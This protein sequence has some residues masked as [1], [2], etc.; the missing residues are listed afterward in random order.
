MRSFNTEKSLKKQINLFLDN[1]LPNEDKQNLIS[2][3]Q[4]DPRSNAIFDRE[5]N[6]RDFIKNNVKRQ[7]ITPDFIQNLKSRLQ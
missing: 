5:K 1:E 4:T 2:K 3:L 7:T 6:F